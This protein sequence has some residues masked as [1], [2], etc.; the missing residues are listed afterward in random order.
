MQSSS[1]VYYDERGLSKF[2][3]WVV[4]W[5]M[6]VSSIYYIEHLYTGDI[7]AA[8][9]KDIFHKA[10]KYLVALGL[11]FGLLLGSRRLVF[12]FVILAL[13]LGLLVAFILE[14]TLMGRLDLIVVVVTMFGLVML[15]GLLN[16]KQRAIFNRTI[17]VS[18]VI[19]GVFAV[20]ERL[21]LSHLYINHWASTGAIRLISTLYN[22]NNMG[23]YEAAC[24]LLL[25]Y[26]KFSS[27][28]KILASPSILYAL[29][30]SG[31]RTAWAALL[32]VVLTKY[33]LTSMRI[34]PLRLVGLCLSLLGAGVATLVFI[35]MS[36]A[37]V[38]ERLTDLQ[39]ASI[40]FERYAEFINGFDFQYFL[41]D[42]DGVRTGL[43]SES[44]Y[45]TL[46]NSLGLIGVLFFLLFAL[47]FFSWRKK[48][49]RQE[50]WIAVLWFYIIA[51]FFENILNSFPNNQMLFIAVGVYFTA[52]R[53]SSTPGVDCER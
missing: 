12:S 34:T 19:V 25:L 42:I 4:C 6:I 5:W 20:V 1:V 18:G 27:R 49:Q 28:L 13:I 7:L 40:R 22:P 44:S 3:F 31:S 23:T 52:R 45:F 8:H 30:M 41:P 46:I 15:L 35:G 29:Y 14:P 33:L 16:E 2:M 32:I 17:I 26:G 47:V 48:C 36:S 50:S 24:L 38:P 39:S 51:A 9:G 21:Y 53:D 10:F 43:V 37:S 11:T